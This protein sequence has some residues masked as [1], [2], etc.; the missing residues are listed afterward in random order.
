MRC[1]LLIS[2]SDHVVMWVSVFLNLYE[3]VQ[4]NQQQETFIIN[5]GLPMIE[6]AA[7]VLHKLFD[8]VLKNDPILH[9]KYKHI[10]GKCLKV[11]FKHC[12]NFF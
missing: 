1:F 7:K 11:Q 10:N 9:E 8:E 2:I 4:V 5:D 6:V 12:D 3:Y